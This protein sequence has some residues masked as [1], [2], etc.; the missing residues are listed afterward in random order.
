MWRY[1][2]RRLLW[3]AF[4]AYLILSVTFLAFAAA[5]PPVTTE[6]ESPIST[7]ARW[8]STQDETSLLTQ[9]T[10]WIVQYATLDFEKE[11]IDRIA[12][13][14][15]VTLAY[16]APAL[17][18]AV[19]GGVVLGVYAA[20]N[21]G[22]LP[23]RFATLATYVVVGIP[24]YW[25]AEWSVILAYERLGVMRKFAYDPSL[26]PW[27]GKN[28]PITLLPLAV[29]LVSMLAVQARYARSESAEHVH[30]EF[31]KTLRANGARPLD[32]ARHVVRNAAMPLLSLFFIRT[33]T[34]LFITVAVAEVVF[35]LPG[36]GWLAL[37]AV[38]NREIDIV[39]LTTMIPV[40]LALFGNL[41]QDVAYVK[42]DPR[43]EFGD[44]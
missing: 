25:I 43:V 20:V 37:W 11:T 18:A 34:M 22:T 3:T 14:L 17:L 7:P 28:L 16:L 13:A 39:I 42:L 36:I 27:S 8:P 38:R 1:L 31:V 15:K 44:R 12:G 40:G 30:A 19:V 24:S 29:V 41:L 4:A 35:G 33:I 23:G 21:R 26:D 10:D 5:P 9:Y 32:V 2:T 6:G